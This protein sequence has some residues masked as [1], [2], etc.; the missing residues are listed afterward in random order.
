MYSAIAG[1]RKA[2]TLMPKTVESHPLAYIAFDRNDR[3][4]DFCMVTFTRL[5]Y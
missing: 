4:L 5:W 1:H 3:L 2:Q